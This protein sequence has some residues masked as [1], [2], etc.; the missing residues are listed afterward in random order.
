[1]KIIE[2]ERE[3][4]QLKWNQEKL[5]L[6]NKINE[7]IELIKSKQVEF[8]TKEKQNELR[9]QDEYQSIE[10]HY[11]DQIQELKDAYKIK[12]DEVRFLKVRQEEH[13]SENYRVNS[14]IGSQF[15]NIGYEFA[16]YQ[17]SSAGFTRGNNNSRKTFLEKQRN[18]VY[19]IDYD[20]ILKV[21]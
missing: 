1:M 16:K 10:E 14:I 6:Q 12:E 7:Y 2:V 11:K 13:D 21:E 18:Q 9:L 20:A 19:K 8:Q 4:D 5:E 15:Y 3:R 17:P